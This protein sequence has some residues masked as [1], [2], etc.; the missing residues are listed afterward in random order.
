MDL[1]YQLL[2]VSIFIVGFIVI[3]YIFYQSYY[4]YYNHNNTLHNVV[5]IL[6]RQCARWAVAA[7][8]DE[9][10]I[11]RVLHANYAAGYLWAI[12]DIVPTDTFKH[13]TGKDFLQFEQKIV[14]IQDEATLK[15]AK[16]CKDSVPTSDQSLMYAIYGK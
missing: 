11:I 14:R 3:S 7:E 12:K 5:Q 16:T 13:I 6:Y 10:E 8:Q 1:L 4:K 15:L 2:I 9:N